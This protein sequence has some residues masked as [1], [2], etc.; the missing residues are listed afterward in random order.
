ME[1]RQNSFISFN[2]KAGKHLLKAVKSEFKGNQQRVNK[3]VDLF[4]QTYETTLDAGTIVD[5]NKN[6]RYV[7]SHELFPN[8]KYM[9]RQSAIHKES[10][11][12]TIITECPKIFGYG[13]QLLFQ[14]I[15]RKT[16]QVLSFD[17]LEKFVT[18]EI[19]SS[20]SLK[21][22]QEV[23]KV[24]RR[25]KTDMPNSKFS[26]TDFELMDNII[27]NEEINTPGTALYNLTRS[28]LSL[29]YK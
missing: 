22:F 13:E 10:L 16:M 1:I 17:E 11:A 20:Q 25:I 12:G 24:A 8:I 5:I 19:Q 21:K 6:K 7:L 23:I 2:A 14:N 28:I 27:G 18:D 15:V 29:T 3:F 26:D 4:E 9:L